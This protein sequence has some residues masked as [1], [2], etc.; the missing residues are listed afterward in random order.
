MDD[1]WR[2]SVLGRVEFLRDCRARNCRYHNVFF[3]NFCRGKRKL[4][5]FYSQKTLQKAVRPGYQIRDRAFYELV[6]E[7]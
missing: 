1:E 5:Q 3:T 7:I 4:K 6:D 2:I